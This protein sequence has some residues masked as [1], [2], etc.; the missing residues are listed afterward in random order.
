[1]SISELLEQYGYVAVLLGTFLE[2]ETIL[3]MAG[4]AVHQGY[5][6][7]TG[8]V[9]CAFIGSLLGDQLAFFLGRKYGPRLVA[10]FDRLRVPVQHA[11]ALLQRYGTPLLLGF[12]FIYGIRNVTP[13]AAGSA[14][15][16]VTRFLLLNICGA[17]L[18]SVVIAAAGYTFGQGFELVIERARRFEELVLII[19]ACAGAAAGILHLIRARRRRL[20]ASHRPEP[21][22]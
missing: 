4:F 18:W 14:H 8:V 17:A 16:P 3:L 9:V 5:L 21:P 1:M 11:S 10:R 20:R 12:R 15:V 6:S 7:F 19:I 22:R 13:L 2:G